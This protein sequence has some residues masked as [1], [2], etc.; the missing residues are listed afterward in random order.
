MIGAE[1]SMAGNRYSQPRESGM[2][3]HRRVFSIRPQ[4]QVPK[5]DEGEGSG[6]LCLQTQ[7]RGH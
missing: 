1:W 5:E 3:S 2:R 7:Q 6:F 4:L